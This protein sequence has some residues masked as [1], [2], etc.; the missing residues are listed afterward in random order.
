MAMATDSVC[1]RARY[2]IRVA[3]GELLDDCVPGLAFYQREHAMAHV[4][5]HHRVTFPMPDVLSPLNFSRPLTKGS[6]A[7][8]HAPRIM[9]AVT[10]ASEFA[11]DPRVAPQVAARLLVPA[12]APVDRFVADAP[13][14]PF[15]EHGG[16]LFGAPFTAQQPRH[17]RHVGGAEARADDSVFGARWR[18]CA[19]SRRDTCHRDGSRC[20]TIPASPCCGAGRA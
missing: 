7:G 2:L 10:L 9:A 20:G 6:L 3:G 8:Q 1:R 5:A 16:N 11:H 15:L 13:R 12:D 17:L 14:P 18:N 19:P 4:T